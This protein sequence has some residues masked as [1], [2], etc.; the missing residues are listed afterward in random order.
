MTSYFEKYLGPVTLAHCPGCGG[1]FRLVRFR[2]WWG[3]K[4]ILRSLCDAC[5]PEKK[6]SDMTPS[7]R[8]NAVA[9]GRVDLERALALDDAHDARVRQTHSVGTLKAHASQRRRNW[10]AAVLRTLRHER[11]WAQR[12]MENAASQEWEAFFRAY[13][14]ALH[15]AVNRIEQRLKGKGRGAPLKPTMEEASPGYWLNADTRLKLKDL[16]SACPVVRGRRFYRDPA[17]L[18]WDF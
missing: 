14:R 10:N 3:D 11:D 12:Y 6:I 17:F 9:A 8:A 15:D 4:R 2:K 16:Y 1:N 13:A 7:E 5:E 18:G